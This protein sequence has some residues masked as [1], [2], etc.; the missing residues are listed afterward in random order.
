MKWIVRTCVLWTMV[1]CCVPATAQVTAAKVDNAIRRGVGYLRS[2]QRANGGWDEFGSYKCGLS[3]L[4]TLALATAG[5]GADDP[6]IENAMRYLRRSEANDTYSVALQTLAFC[7][8]GAAEDLPRIRRNVLW[9]E[10][11]QI[12][13]AN[14]VID[15]TGSW[16]YRAQFDGLGDPSNTQFALLALA[17]AEERGVTVSP[18]AF[19]QSLDYW[20]KLQDNTGGWPYSPDFSATGSMT[21]AGIAST[22]ICRG[23]LA[24]GSSSI[25]GGEI[26]C[27]GADTGDQR[28]E[29]GLQWLGTHFTVRANPGPPSAAQNL[30]YY[31]YALERVGRL[32]G[33][34]MIGGHD[35][36]R[37]GSEFLLQIQNQIQGYWAGVGSPEDNRNIST[38]FALLFLSKGKRQVVLGRLRYDAA[39]DGKH[40]EATRQLVR[41]LERDWG[42]DLTWQNVQLDNAQVADLLQTP[43]LLIAGNQP[44]RFSDPDKNKLKEYVEQGGFILFE[45]TAGNGCGSPEPFANSVNQLCQELFQNPLERLPPTHPVW[46]AE[47]R[48]DPAEIGADF[49]V[50]G[51]QACCRTAVV[52]VPAA[53]TCRWELSDPAGRIEYPAA[54]AKQID[55]AVSLGQNIVAYATGRELKDKLDLPSVL[56]Q[57]TQARA[58]ARGVITVPRLAIGAGGEDAG[59]AV[60]NLARYVDRDAPIR[61]TTDSPLVP[62]ESSALQPYIVAWVHGRREFELNDRQIE[63]LREYL[64]NGGTLLIDSICGN[65]AFSQSVRQQIGRVLPDS[66]L[67]P[68]P[69]DHPLFTSAYGG[70]DLTSVTLQTP[71]RGGSGAITMQKRTTTANLEGATVD[72]RIVVLFSPYD[73]SC[74]LESQSSLQCPGYTTEDAAKI[75]INMLLFTLLQ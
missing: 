75:G 69:S 42:R 63:T 32:S 46:F 8:I 30:F 50:Y 35:W 12:S 51:V 4:C 9:L 58:G 57:E 44:L 52:F 7:Q 14:K 10:K 48:V 60:P 73:L 5:V 40:P 66:P 29:R 47:R 55:T 27:C 26:Q 33:R 17:A 67:Q 74:A 43:V 39:Q 36:Y 34:R 37:E 68:L 19:K 24:D 6:A 70:Y 3:S 61:I 25:E 1:A 59:R 54:I 20:S 53:L 64:V 22:I 45:A 11:S 71:L 21:C 31:L 49:W 13:G 15:R 56:V 23:Q 41:H 18:A 28:I 72:G 38:S 16:T 62:L 65:E 2:Q